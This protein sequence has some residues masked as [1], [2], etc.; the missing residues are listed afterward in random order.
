M[1]RHARLVR[2]GRRRRCGHY[3]RDSPPGKP[4]GARVVGSSAVAAP[5]STPHPRVPHSV[6]GTDKRRAHEPAARVPRHF[7]P[8][9]AAPPC[10]HRPGSTLNESPDQR[11]SLIDP[12]QIFISAVHVFIYVPDRD[13]SLDNRCRDS[14]CGP[15]QGRRGAGSRNIRPPAR[16]RRSRACGPRA[17]STEH[18]I[19]GQSAGSG[20]SIELSA[21]EHVRP[22]RH[23]D[24]ARFHTRARPQRKIQTHLT[25]IVR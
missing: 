12:N 24:P 23:D 6:T 3:M 11:K 2:R 21:H 1:V 15:G 9:C 4:S 16:V 17:C 7:L 22:S 18:R 8:P 19:M 5:P 20:S 10:S 13:F 25:V 14:A